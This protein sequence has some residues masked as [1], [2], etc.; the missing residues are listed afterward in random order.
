MTFASSSLWDTA[1]LCKRLQPLQESIRAATDEARPIN[2]MW[3]YVFS[4]SS[5]SHRASSGPLAAH[6]RAH[7]SE[8][9]RLFTPPPRDLV[10]V[11][12]PTFTPPDDGRRSVSRGCRA[13]TQVAWSIHAREVSTVCPGPQSQAYHRLGELFSRV[14]PYVPLDSAVSTHAETQ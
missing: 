1:I 6:T 4:K 8:L 10:S 3:T 14:F 12:S 2:R 11:S 7:S 9:R 13:C 5:H